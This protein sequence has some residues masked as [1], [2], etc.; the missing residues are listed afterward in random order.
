MKM[1]L[2]DLLTRST[3]LL[4]MI[5]GRGQSIV[6]LQCL[7]ILVPGPGNNGAAEIKFIVFRNMSSLNM[8]IHVSGLADPEHYTKG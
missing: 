7:H 8:I 6:Y 3:L 2:T 5:G 1:L 4:H